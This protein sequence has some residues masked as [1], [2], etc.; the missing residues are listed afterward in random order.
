MLRARSLFD[1]KS[2][3]AIFRNR[4]YFYQVKCILANEPEVFFNL[5]A[6]EYL[7][8]H[9]E[10]EACMLWQSQPAVVVGKHQNALAEI[11]YRYT[12]QHGITVARRLTGGGTVYHDAGNLNF[13]L[14]RRGE[15]GRMIDF[16]KHIEVITDFLRSRGIEATKGPKHEIL[17][18]DRKISGNAEHV[19]KNRVLHHGT[20]LF[21]ADLT[22]LRAA[23]RQQGGNY[24][25][26]AVRSNPA[27]VMNLTDLAWPGADMEQFRDD[28]YE[29]LLSYFRGSPYV[30]TSEEEKVIRELVSEKYTTWDWIY[31]WSPDYSFS[32]RI[33][34]GGMQAFIRF[35]THRGVIRDFIIET[36]ILSLSERNKLEHSFEHLAHRY[37]DVSEVLRGSALDKLVPFQDWEDLVYSFF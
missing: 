34:A 10:E 22:V 6:E 24:R 26:R 7:L 2:V 37:E 32:N 19:Y 12:R 21:K 25:D 20:L 18:G 11:G 15:A 23:I 4:S 36:D 30:L 1:H 9:Y 8:K 31:G 27:R 35:S 28:L 14:I 29:F 5:A 33:D 16:G 17:V 13:T 3:V